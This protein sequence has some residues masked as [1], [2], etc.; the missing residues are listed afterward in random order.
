MAEA[1]NPDGM[2]DVLPPILGDL[3]TYNDAC[4]T[5]AEDYIQSCGIVVANREAIREPL[6]ACTIVETAFTLDGDSAG[7]AVVDSYLAHSFF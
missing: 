2:I 3:L 1:V 7:F 5:L 4:L 6:E